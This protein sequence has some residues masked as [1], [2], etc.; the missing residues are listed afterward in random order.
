M[1]RL[2][3]RLDFGHGLTFFVYYAHATY[4]LYCTPQTHALLGMRKE[5]TIAL[6][7]LP[8][9]WAFAVFFLI[10]GSLPY[11]WMF[12]FGLLHNSSLI[13]AK[14]TLTLISNERLRES[15]TTSPTQRVQRRPPFL[16]VDHLP[17]TDHREG[18]ESTAPPVSQST[19]NDETIRSGSY[20]HSLRDDSTIP[21]NYSESS[22]HKGQDTLVREA[23]EEGTTS[24]VDI[25]LI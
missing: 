17:V 22:S 12:F 20:A 8:I 11:T 13:Q 24:G 25:T 4:S 1:E 6:I 2:Q 5:H 14:S 23:Y 3:G 10:I 19:F 18:N 9:S 16:V 7:N 21:T 15:N